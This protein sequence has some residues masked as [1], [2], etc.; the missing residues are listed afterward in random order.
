MPI[1]IYLK[2]KNYSDIILNLFLEQFKKFFCS[3]L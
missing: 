1:L 3:K 2:F